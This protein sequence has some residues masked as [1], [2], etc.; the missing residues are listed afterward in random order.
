MAVDTPRG[1]RNNNPFN[2]KKSPADKWQ[3]LADAQDDIVF[4]VFK[5]AVY[6][7]RAGLRNLIAAQDK[8]NR[9]D[10]HDIIA[11]YA[12]PSENNTAAY[13]AAVAACMGKSPLEKLDMHN[14]ADLRGMGE[15]I[16]AHENGAP[17]TAFYSEGQMAK[18]MVMAGVEAP[19]KALLASR[20]VIGGGIA[21]AA[22]VAAPVVQQVQEQLAPLTSYSDWVKSAFL[23]VALLG[24]VLAIWAKYDERRKGIS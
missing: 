9:R 17:W 12:P 22:T 19:K 6:G 24:I 13:I 11:A 15:A 7:I 5:D 18:A 20:Q 3:G 4:F 16:I 10:I 1:V 21:A 8:H 14:Y 2:L 23:G